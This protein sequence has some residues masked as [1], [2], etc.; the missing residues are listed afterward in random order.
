MKCLLRLLLLTSL[1]G[2]SSL[3]AAQPADAPPE[4]EVAEPLPVAAPPAGPANVI[5]G[6]R[7]ARDESE[8]QRAVQAGPVRP[9][10]DAQARR[11]MQDA[12]PAAITRPSRSIPRGTIVVQVLDPAGQPVSGVGVRIG[13]MGQAGERSADQ[14]TT[15]ANGIYTVS[16]QPTGSAQAYRVTVPH[17]GATYGATPFRLEP[18]QGQEV[19]VRLLPTTRDASVLLQLQGQTVF[20]FR[21]NRLHVIQQTQLTNLGDETYVFPED[22]LQVDL[23]DGFTGFQSQAVMTDQRIIPNDDGFELRGSLMPGRVTLTWGYDLDMQAGTTTVRAAMPFRTY[24]YRVMTD[25][26]PGMTLEVE[27][28]PEARAHESDGRSMLF[29]QVERT[30]E[31]APMDHLVIHLRGVPG[32]G[33][34]RW[35]AVGAAL[36]LILAGLLFA[37]RGGDRAAQSLR[38][39]DER[40]AELLDDAADLEAMFASGE[41]GA[42]FRH[43]RLEEIAIELAAILRIDATAAAMGQGDKS[44]R[45]A[46]ARTKG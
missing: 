33:P 7:Q 16:D 37:M 3:A 46:A 38:A 6:A 45:S 10:E 17:E 14:G 22:G 41:V 12:P 31:D 13:I 34:L 39:R 43:R 29:T 15:D 32:P 26:T 42:K 20:E 30:P 19:R 35:V 9:P 18:D 27:G 28:F 5:S 8:A 44:S 11:A 4:G 36:I 21:E 2:V 24:R 23:P 25:A 40:K 1:A